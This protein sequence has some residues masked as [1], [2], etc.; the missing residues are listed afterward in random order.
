MM[1]SFAATFFLFI[2]QHDGNDYRS[3]GPIKHAQNRHISFKI[4]H[5]G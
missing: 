2:T 3:G 5:G 4:C 1:S